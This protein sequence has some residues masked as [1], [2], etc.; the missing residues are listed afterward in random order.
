MIANDGQ[1]R[2]LMAK[3]A[4]EKVKH[5]DVKVITAKWAELLGIK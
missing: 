4:T 1:L 3:N 2:S 5:F